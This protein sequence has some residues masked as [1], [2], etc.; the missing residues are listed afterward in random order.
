[1]I[2][3][4]GVMVVMVVV[5]FQGDLHHA[6]GRDNCDLSQSSDMIGELYVFGRGMEMGGTSSCLFLDFVARFF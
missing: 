4:V 2:P 3:G 1:M 6:D 5:W